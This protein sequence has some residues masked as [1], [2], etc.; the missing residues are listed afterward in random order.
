M[1]FI[2]IKQKSEQELR[3]LLDTTRVELMQAQ[4]QAGER[5]LK[6]VRKI[7]TLRRTIARILTVLSG[8]N[9]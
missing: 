5:Q 2:D 8:L 3:E 9:A 6:N 7:R 4:F 1:N